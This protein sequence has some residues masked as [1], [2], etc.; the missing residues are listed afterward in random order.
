MILHMLAAV[1]G[2]VGETDAVLR[3]VLTADYG[4]VLILVVKKSPQTYTQYTRYF[5]EG[6]Q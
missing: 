1:D 5:D 2:I 3:L 6:S 4:T